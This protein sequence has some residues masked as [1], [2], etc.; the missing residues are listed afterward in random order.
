MAPLRLQVR[1][2]STSKFPVIMQVGD[3]G[4]FVE[5]GKYNSLWVNAKHF[6]FLFKQLGLQY[7]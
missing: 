2:N 5:G 1:A 3:G 6:S 4:H 7:E